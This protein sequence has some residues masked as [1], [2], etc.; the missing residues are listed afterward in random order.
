MG[1]GEKSA[2]GYSDKGRQGPIAHFF[3]QNVEGQGPSTPRGV[4]GPADCADPVFAGA[5]KKG[6]FQ[7]FEKFNTPIAP[8]RWAGGFKRFAHSAGPGMVGL[9]GSGVDGLMGSSEWQVRSSKWQVK[10][11]I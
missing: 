2:K 10:G 5:Q 9:M 8:P 6:K 4:L 7:R 1:R 3:G 11:A